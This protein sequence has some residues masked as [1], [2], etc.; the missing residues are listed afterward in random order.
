MYSMVKSTVQIN[1][2]VDISEYKKLIAFLKRQNDNY[3]PKKSKILT[4][5][6]VLTFLNTAPDETF[7]LLK[8][9]LI[10][11]LNGACRRA[12]LC[13]LK[14]KDIENTGSI[15]I[16]TLHDTKTKKKR[17]FTITSECKGIEYYRKYASLRPKNVSHDR[18][19]LFYKNGKCSVQP[20]G[21]N[22]FAKMPKKIAEYLELPDSGSYTGHCLRRTSATLLADSGADIQT[23]KRHGGWASTSVA[24]GYV[25]ESISNKV[26]ISRKIFSATESS[27]SI[28]ETQELLFPEPHS[29]A[30][31]VNVQS[32]SVT[33]SNLSNCVFNIYTDK[34]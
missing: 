22:S 1:E 12:E 2:N 17:I 31:P 33:F 30:A 11:G 21:I 23:L 25:E 3:E 32:S 9:V 15:V 29:A 7:L 28:C 13:S 19:F 27:S 5:E 10:F 14:T 4:M 20:V 16:V 24:E 8:V 6:N 34:K 18:F 26:Q